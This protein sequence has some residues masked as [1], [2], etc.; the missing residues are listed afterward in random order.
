VTANLD[1]KNIPQHIGIILDGNRR[2]AQERHLSDFEGHR[3]G[4]E[5]MRQAPLWFFARG[6]KIV[7]V[8]AFS[9]ENWQ[10]KQEEVNYLMK[11]FR[12]TIDAELETEKEKGYRVVVSGRID[13]LPGDLPE[14]IYKLESST[15]SNS[16][17]I[18]NICLNYGGKAEIIDAV[19]KMVRNNV[20]EDQVHEGMIG[21]YLYNSQI[22]NDPDLIIR[23]SGEMRLSGFMLWRS[24]YSELIFLKKFW[25]EF[26][27]A[28]ADFV[29]KEYAERQRRFGG[30]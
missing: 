14:A 21:K 23:T 11:I 16:K 25:P 19:K 18:L 27:E 6:V 13:E 29:L 30:N 5:K 7:S 4:M 8:F 20:A 10:R 17:G 3:R 12:E 9:T 15:A 24:A 26:E 28:D 2:W 1:N 22:L